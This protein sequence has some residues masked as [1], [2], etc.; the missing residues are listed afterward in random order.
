MV[1]SKPLAQTRPRTRVL[2]FDF[3]LP[4]CRAAGALTMWIS[5]PPPPLNEDFLLVAV[6]YHDRVA[7]LRATDGSWVQQ[8]TGGD[9]NLLQSPVGV[10]GGAVY[11]GK[12]CVGHPSPSRHLF[13][14]H[15]RRHVGRLTGRGSRQR[16]HG[17]RM[18]IWFGG[19]RRSKL[20]PGM[21]FFLF[22]HLHDV[23]TFPL[24]CCYS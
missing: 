3:F 6:G 8:L 21:L 2:S 14:L 17:F 23:V 15:R 7:V 12:S 10:A 16:P 20:H 5:P 24:T 1:P 18:P 22:R 13:L 11:G 4:V 9:P 19:A